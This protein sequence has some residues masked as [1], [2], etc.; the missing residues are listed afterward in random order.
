MRAGAGVSA[1]LHAG[2]IALAIFSGELFSEGQARPVTIAEV[3]LMSGAEFEAALSAAPQFDPDQPAAPAA[4]EPGGERADVT[5]A[6]SDAAPTRPEESTPPD[7]PER[8]E[9]VA[10]PRDSPPD[11]ALAEAGDRPAAPLAP[12]DDRLVAAPQT[13]PDEAPVT[14]TAPAPPP[15]PRP[16]EPQVDTSTPEPEPVKPEPVET[17]E[18][19]P[20]PAPEPEP[21]QTPE[22][23]EPPAPEVV[24]TAEAE[25]EAEKLAPKVAPPPPSKPERVEVA[26][27]AEREA[28]PEKAPEETGATREAAAPSGGGTTA[29]VGRLSSRDRDNLR[30]GIGSNF[31]WTRGGPDEDSMRVTIRIEVDVDGQIVGKPEITAP[32]GALSQRESALASAGVR[33]LVKSEAKGEFRK[34]P[35]DKHAEWRIMN[36]TFTPREVRFL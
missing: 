36:V 11:D 22:T 4:P 2:L 23:E 21:K 12:A 3:T 17:T 8:G 25:P 9:A 19:A 26:Q 16:S 24:E 15:A 28:R 13:P 33:A 32:S 34:L 27:E 7:A 31:S 10:P 20:T 18:A 6:E 1:G 30:V 29:T 5:I 14:E 35:K